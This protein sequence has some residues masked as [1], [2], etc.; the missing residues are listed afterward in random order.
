MAGSPSREQGLRL[1]SEFPCYGLNCSLT[2]PQKNSCVE[3]LILNAS[4]GNLI[5]RQGL[6][7]GIKLK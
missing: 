2:P 6:Y 4:E 5:W 7:R 1:E 3:V